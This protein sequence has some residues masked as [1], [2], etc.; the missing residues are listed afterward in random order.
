VLQIKAALNA[1]EEVFSRKGTASDHGF[2]DDGN[3]RHNARGFDISAVL[4]IL[5]PYPID[6]LGLN[7]D[8]TRPDGRAYPLPVGS[9]ICD[10]FASPMLGCQKML[11]VMPTID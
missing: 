7:C 9:F 10:F 5:Q 2:R 3:H 11:A 8:G 1:I 6:I 4:T